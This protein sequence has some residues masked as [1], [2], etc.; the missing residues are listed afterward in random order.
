MSFQTEFSK[1]MEVAGE[2]NPVVRMIMQQVSSASLLID[3]KDTYT[4]IGA[5]VVVYICFLKGINEGDVIRCGNFPF[6]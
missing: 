3:N 5:G 2:K 6:V 4:D 1:D